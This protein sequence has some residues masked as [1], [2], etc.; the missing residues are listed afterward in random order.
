MAT[1]ARS[2]ASRAARGVDA[3]QH[4][5]ELLAAEPADGVGVADHVAQRRG[6]ERERA[7]ALG[8][9]EGV[10]DPLEVVEVDDDDAHRPAVGLVERGPQALLAAAVVE[11]AGEAVRA[12]LL[13]QQ[14]A[15]ARG[16][17]GQRGHRREALHELD[18]AVGEGDVGARAV[19][20]ERAD[21]AVVG[22][23]RHG[24][25]RLGGLVGAGD[26]GA[27]RLVQRVGHVAGAAVAHDPARDPAQHRDLLGHDL[28]D[29]VADGEHGLE[30]VAA[31]LDLVEREIVERD[32]RGEVVRDPAE[33]AR[34]RVG[35]E[36]PR[37]GVDE[38]L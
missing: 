16:V 6:G 15:L 12:D 30:R 18:L 1:R 13:A 10:V 35:C 4:E 33:R 22:D 21:D 34:Q 37:R 7:V 29:P 8:V 19:D 25:E 17:V 31:L 11:Q 3:R 20:V 32:E 9:A 24:D 27:Q 2:A 28:V 23:Q 36:D 14:V 5:H 26:D 38:R